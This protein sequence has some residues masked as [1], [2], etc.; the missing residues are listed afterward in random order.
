MAIVLVQFELSDEAA[1]E[2][3][4]DLYSEQQL[5]CVWIHGVNLFHSHVNNV[6]YT[7]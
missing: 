4:I 5:T 3:S 2:F 7:M 1:S 6:Q